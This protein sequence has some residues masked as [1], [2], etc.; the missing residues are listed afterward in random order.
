MFAHIGGL[1]EVKR[2]AGAR[3]GQHQY[4]GSDRRVHK[5]QVSIERR[6]RVIESMHQQC[7]CP[8]DFGDV[9]SAEYGV[10]HKGAGDSPALMRPVDRETAHEHDR[11]RVR[12]VAPDVARRGS[13]HDRACGEAVVGN[14]PAVLAEG[15]GFAL[16]P[17]GY[18]ALEHLRSER[19]YRE[20]ELDLTPEDTP[21][22]AGLDFTVR[23]G[24]PYEFIGRDAV[25]KQKE[26]GPLTRR[27]VM[28]RLKDREPVLFGEEVIRMDGRIAGYLSSGA[29][30]FTRGASV[31][32]G[33]IRHPDGVTREL[34]ESVS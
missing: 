31:G 16:R 28:F 29:Y 13:M 14:D 33:Y 10:S 27:L 25:L 11:N 18:H 24:K 7:S 1:R 34:I 9:Q 4:Q 8:G 26:A 12:H 21:F 15:E 17:A 2:L 23:L 6:G 30:G 3:Q 20:Y 5:P 32:M 19:A 22:E